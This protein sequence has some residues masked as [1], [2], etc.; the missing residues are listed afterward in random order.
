MTMDLYLATINTPG[1]LPQDDDRHVFTD[2]REA[3]AY[4]ISERNR[5]LND[6]DDMGPN[7]DHT[8]ALMSSCIGGPRGDV[9]TVYGPT[10]GYDG[11]HDLGIAYTVSLWAHADYPHHPGYLPQCGP[12]EY[13]CHCDPATDTTECVHCGLVSS[14]E[15]VCEYGDCGAVGHG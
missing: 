12:C 2:P 3:W 14:D 8:T 1:Y 5:S 4:L 15:S 9:A 6:L 13:A 11:A 7:Y 10:P